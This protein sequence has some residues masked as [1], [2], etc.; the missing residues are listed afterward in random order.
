MTIYNVGWSM[1]F[2]LMLQ[3][4]VN[5]A[6]LGYN[7]L[8]KVKAFIARSRRLLVQKYLKAREERLRAIEELENEKK[9]QAIAEGTN[10][11]LL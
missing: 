2:L 8:I 4:S 7:T 10:K 11:V 9:N 3:F 5:I 1:D 6:S